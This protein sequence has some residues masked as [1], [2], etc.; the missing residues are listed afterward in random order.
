MLEEI[1]S[2]RLWIYTSILGALCGA[3]FLQYFKGTKAGVWCYVKFD[4]AVDFLRDRY[5]WSWLDQPADAW[6]KT[7]PHIAE[8]IDELEA[9]ITKLEG[10]K[11]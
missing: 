2:D 9:R 10:K 6:K 5:G 8:K 1:F 7:Y 11:K 4:H 3:A